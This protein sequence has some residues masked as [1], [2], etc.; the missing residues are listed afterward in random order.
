MSAFNL[1]P[2]A[3]VPPI[4]DAAITPPDAMSIAAKER[5]GWK[6]LPKSCFHKHKCELKCRGCRKAFRICP[7]DRCFV[8]HPREIRCAECSQVAQERWLKG[9]HNQ[10]IPC[11]NCWGLSTCSG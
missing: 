10:L 8:S 2:T 5:R 11:P 3:P 7:D 1:P 4:S 9:H 6:L